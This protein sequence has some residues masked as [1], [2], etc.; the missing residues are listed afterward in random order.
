MQ[1]MTAPDD[2]VRGNVGKSQFGSKNGR[3]LQVQHV[4]GDVLDVVSHCSPSPSA[5]GV[6]VQAHHMNAP[7]TFFHF[8]FILFFFFPFLL[9]FLLFFLITFFALLHMV[10]AGLVTSS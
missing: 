7:T 9:F 2:P 1:L 6:H 10:W 8:S 5:T 3:K 4:E